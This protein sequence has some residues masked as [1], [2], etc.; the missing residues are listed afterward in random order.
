MN[1]AY[2]EDRSV[3]SLGGAPKDWT[4]S[5]ESAKQSI[6]HPLA[7]TLDAVH[8]GGDP[9]H[10]QDAEIHDTALQAADNKINTQEET[11]GQH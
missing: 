2:N 5:G 10:A 1:F 3:A 6:L 11:E 9:H 7:D 8:F 4:I